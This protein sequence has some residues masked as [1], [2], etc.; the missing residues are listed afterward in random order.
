MIL[1]T[2]KVKGLNRLKID[3][4]ASCALTTQLNKETLPADSGN[5]LDD[6]NASVGT[7]Q[8]K[9][10]GGTDMRLPA[11]LVITGTDSL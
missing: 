1:L 4:Q 10:R 11:L 6:L 8:A 2:S 5:F 7:S 9:G 3:R